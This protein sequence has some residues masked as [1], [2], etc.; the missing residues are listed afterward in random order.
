M[1][2]SHGVLPRFLSE[3]FTRNCFPN[4]LQWSPEICFRYFPEII[5]RVFPEFLP[6]I[7]PVS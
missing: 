1:F 3:G 2:I 5:P 7:V 4:L 6:E